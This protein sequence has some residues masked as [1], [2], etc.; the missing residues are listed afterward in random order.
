MTRARTAILLGTA[1][2][3]LPRAEAQQVKS[4]DAVARATYACP[5][6][7]DREARVARALELRDRRY[8][9]NAVA[10]A[11]D[12]LFAESVARAKDVE[13]A[14]EALL[15]SLAYLDVVTLLKAHDLA[16][17]YVDEWKVR[18]EHGKAQAKALSERLNALAANDPDVIA[19]EGTTLL[20]VH[21]FD[22]LITVAH[23]VRKARGLLER[24]VELDPM[25]FDGWA[26]TLLGRIHFELPAILGGDSAKSVEILERAFAQT[27]GNVQLLR[28]LAESYDQELQETKAIA[29]LQRIRDLPD[30]ASVDLQLT[31]DELRLAQ[32]LATRLAHE[33]LAA[34]LQARRRALLETH[35]MLDPRVSV[36]AAGH[37]GDNP[38]TGE[39]QY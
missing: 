26:L 14:K 34:G 23:S 5:E 27:P 24:A 25:A 20:V 10:C 22:N 35:P 7:P 39:A 17:T 3:L 32:G 8:D 15:A 6:V 13:L 11:A 36:Q 38:I 9:K 37:G 19:M 18:L 16:G 12:I 21:Q 31:V 1:L 4:P 2:L 33:A 29:M 30:P 28:Y